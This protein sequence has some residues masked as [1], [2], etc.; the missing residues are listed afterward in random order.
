MGYEDTKQKILNTLM[1][2]PD[3]EEIQPLNHQ[4]FALSLLEY[5][6][7]VELFSTSV[8]I[9]IANEDT[10]PL[11]PNDSSVV[12][13]SAISEQKNVVF[14]NFLDKDGNAI[15]IRTDKSESKLVMFVWNKQYWDKQEISANVVSKQDNFS[16]SMRIRKTY[17]STESMYADVYNPIGNDGKAINVGEIVSVYNE[18]DPTQNGMYSYEFDGIRKYWQLQ[19][20]LTNLNRGIDG[21]RADSIY[22]ST[23]NIDCGGAQ[24]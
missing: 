16:Y 2:R 18:D 6:R 17:S 3:G 15:I 9:A 11:Q 20:K 7:S 13:I 14:K 1:Q 4:D 8:P 23:M 19:I 5:I 21:G 24:I 12:Y 10:V 22:S